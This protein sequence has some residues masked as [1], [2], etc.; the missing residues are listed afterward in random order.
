[1]REWGCGRARF[2]VEERW[3]SAGLGRSKITWPEEHGGS[4][5]PIPDAFVVIEGL[6]KASDRGQ[7]DSHQRGPSARAQEECPSGC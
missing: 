1:M 5:R 3:R 4:A 6:T 7:R 2:P